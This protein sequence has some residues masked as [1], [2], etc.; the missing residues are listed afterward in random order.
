MDFVSLQENNYIP[1]EI[2]SFF[3]NIRKIF[4]NS[5]FIKFFEH[6]NVNFFDTDSMFSFSLHCQISFLH[7]RQEVVRC[8]IKIENILI[9]GK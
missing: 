7:H 8:Q 6:Y 1:A 9:I 3:I 5:N 4:K 2:D